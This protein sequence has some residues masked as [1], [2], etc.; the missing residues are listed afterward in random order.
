MKHYGVRELAS[1]QSGATVV[2]AQVQ[3]TALTGELNCIC[4]T[5]HDELIVLADGAIDYEHGSVAAHIAADTAVW[6]Y[7]HIRQRPY[8]WN[9]KHKLLDR[10]FHTVNLTLWQKH[11]EQGFERGV[12]SAL[13]VALIGSQSV[14]IGS[15]GT[16]PV[17]LYRDGL[18]DDVTRRA[19]KINFAQNSLHPNGLGVQRFGV[20]PAIVKERMLQGDILLLLSDAV[21]Q[22]VS[23]DVIRSACEN[24]GSTQ[25]SMTTSLRHMVD[26]IW[27]TG[28][29]S[30]VS[31]GMVLKPRIPE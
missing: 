14:W 23:E 1:G 28:V 7:R 25:E 2:F 6:G 11:R 30:S 21:A 16:N 10:I 20:H 31:I 13:S 15:M 26:C 3:S 19:G 5:F 17:Y 24:S 22:S 29:T 4:S 8:Y 27:P 18:L 9:I 12:S